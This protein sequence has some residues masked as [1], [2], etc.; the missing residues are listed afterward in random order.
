LKGSL[1][2]FLAIVISLSS[3]VYQRKT[4]PTYPVTGH[5]DISG[6]TIDFKLTRTHGGEGDQPVSL[7]APEEFEGT[8][9][10]R[11]YPTNRPW[12]EIGMTRADNVL[13]AALPHQ[14][15]AGKLEYYIVLTDGSRE[16]N[17]PG[18][19][20]H[21]ITRF[22]GHVPAAILLPHIFLMFT[23]MIV[24]NRAGLEALINGPRILGLS[25]VS[26]L[27]LVA[28]GLILGCAV[29]TYAF[30]EPWTGFPLGHDL[31]DNK[32]AVAVIFW[33][34]PLFIKK[35]VNRRRWWVLTAALVTLVIFLI[36]HSLFGSELQYD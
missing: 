23:A 27:S 32:L 13:T 28:G 8:V 25:T 30:G 34:I 1:L 5:I 35:H 17:L 14:P 31:T 7:I 10:W 21:V 6:E 4:G 22:K 24:S 36:P 15:P 2:W 9:F 3:A 18:N 26:F 33:A 19:D 20:G 29:Q 11:H 12:T 16:I